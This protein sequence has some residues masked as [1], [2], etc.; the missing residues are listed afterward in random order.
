VKTFFQRLLTG[1]VLAFALT[2]GYWGLCLAS[3]NRWAMYFS[4]LD[5]WAILSLT[6]AGGTILGTGAF[7]LEHLV[8]RLKPLLVASF[9][10]WAALAL[11][12]NF[13]A[14]RQ[15]IVKQTGWTWLSGTLWW[16][17]VWSAGASGLASALRPGHWRNGAARG[18]F[19]LRR[20][21][22][23]VLFV[24][25]FAV[26]RLP[27]LEAA[28]GRGLDFAR[29]PGNGKPPVVVFMFDML[30][31]E[32]LFDE[33]GEVR[34]AYTNFARFCETA[35]V[36]HAA[37]SAG[38]ETA[39]SLPGFIVQS[40][41]ATL[42]RRLRYTFDDW[43]FADGTDSVRPKDFAAQSLPVLSRKCGGRAQAI[44]MYVPW[45]S[46]LPNAWNTTES[47]ALGYGNQGVHVFGRTPSF[48]TAV[49]GHL[50]WYFL[51]ASKSPASAMAKLAGIDRQAEI[52]GAY[53]ERVSLVARTERFLEEALSPGDFLFIHL[54]MPHGPYVVGR[55][56]VH[57][58]ASLQDDE[59]GG[60]AAQTEAADWAL[61][62]W[63]DA[64]ASSAAGEG[65]WVLVTGDHNLHHPLY[66]KGPMTHVPF[67]VHRPGQTERREVFEPADLTDL[68]HVVPDLPL[69]AEGEGTE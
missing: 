3:V 19:I 57:L 5:F 10:A 69:F 32:E 15:Q 6:L 36:F 1:W 16:L 22:W 60:L 66:R 62:V 44:G 2:G 46:I 59:V 8:P 18:W 39:T 7:V 35:D 65:A 25:P 48:W 33:A 24:I 55:N 40:H 28:R 51:V 42:P 13:P 20:V 31:Y 41:L 14:L 17:A 23:P 53:N 56:G 50:L 67:L 43:L 26:W 64:I 4:R 61:G 12:N 52:D 38:E 49:K 45:D 68:E 30:G 47:M 11:A 58:P 27:S 21:C 37:E 63:M 54:D 9:W 29:V 34:P